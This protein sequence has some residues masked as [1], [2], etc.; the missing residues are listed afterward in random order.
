MALLNQNP[1]LKQAVNHSGRQG[2]ALLWL[3]LSDTLIKWMA[4]LL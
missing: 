2:M 4:K 1:A 3:S